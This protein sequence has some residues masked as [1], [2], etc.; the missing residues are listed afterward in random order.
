MLA[1]TLGRCGQARAVELG[2]QGAGSP[3][4]LPWVPIF[5]LLTVT[6]SEGIIACSLF[7][8]LPFMVED[9][10]LRL[11]DV[12]FFAGLLGSAYNFSQF[13][14]GVHWG[15][16]SDVWGRRPVLIIGVSTQAAA[17]VLFG[18]SSS[19]RQ[20]LLWRFLGG[21]LNGNTGVGRAVMRDLTD[22]SNRTRGF[23]LL[24]TA[25]GM[26]FVLGPALGGMLAR[27]A[28]AFPELFGGTL[29][30][31]YPYLLPSAASTLGCYPALLCMW[32]LPS[33]FATPPRAPPPAQPPR[34][35][36]ELVVARPD[37]DGWHAP[38]SDFAA[39]SAN[40]TPRRAA[41]ATFGS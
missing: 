25:Y 32:F 15:R 38:A 11:S 3:T 39:S 14:S 23:A 40:T 36:T 28:E 35:D 18:L 1:A 21:L 12:G 29:L 33:S 41:R 9:F 16:L 19:L 20:A 30:E 17:M 6:M 2:D 22:E 26:G 31:T 34:A 27:P 7:P 37:S 10:G 8:F 4:A 24:G 5:A 13:L